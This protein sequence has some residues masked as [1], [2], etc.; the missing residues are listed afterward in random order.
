MIVFSEQGHFEIKNIDAEDAS[1]FSKNARVE[2]EML[3]GKFWL[4]SYVNKKDFAM[5]IADP[6]DSAHKMW[7]RLRYE[8]EKL[9]KIKDDPDYVDIK[10]YT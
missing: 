1:W 7:K 10:D 9:I 8:T 6:M 4:R 2:V 3:A 5:V